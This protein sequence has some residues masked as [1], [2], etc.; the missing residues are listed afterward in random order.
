MCVNFYGSN[1]NFNKQIFNISLL[2]YKMSDFELTNRDM[3]T[4]LK[5]YLSQKGKFKMYV[6]IK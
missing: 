2:D 1:C 5:Y 3:I 4:I 6:L